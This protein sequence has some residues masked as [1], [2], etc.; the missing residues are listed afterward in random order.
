MREPNVVE[1]ASI[2]YRILNLLPISSFFA[3]C[4]LLV[5]LATRLIYLVQVY[6]TNIDKLDVVNSILYLVTELGIFR[7]FSI[8]IYSPCYSR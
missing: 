8:A 3:T 7:R 4:T 2:K 5:Y 1:L 6:N